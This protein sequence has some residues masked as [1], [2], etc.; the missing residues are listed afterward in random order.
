M[1]NCHIV[2]CVDPEGER[3]QA[4]ADALGIPEAGVFENYPEL[5]STVAPEVVS[6]C[7]PRQA[8]SD[9]VVGIAETGVPAA[10]HCE[11]PLGGT[12][13]ETRNMVAA[14]DRAGVGL[15]FDR[16]RRYSD[17]FR[18]AKALLDDGA[19]G[20]LQRVEGH[21]GPS[22]ESAV[23]AVDACNY[24]DDDRRASWAVAQRATERPDAADAS[25]ADRLFLTWRFEDGVQGR[26]VPEETTGTDADLRLV[27][28]EGFIDLH[29]TEDYAVR[30]RGA[31][32]NTEKRYETLAR[33]ESC[34][35][36]AIATAIDG[37]EGGRRSGPVGDS[38][39]GAPEILFGG[40]E[41]VGRRGRVPLPL[42]GNGHRPRR[43]DVGRRDPQPS[44]D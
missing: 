34:T 32:G 19:I 14:C 29:V 44:D 4:V 8:R 5:L 13:D 12:W 21:W 41:S 10:V 16:G 25:L 43:R 42:D 26:V 1:E 39:L 6:I 31:N 38:P 40:Y 35:Q 30:V 9:L 36:R 20:T 23:A 7:T 27:G 37:L 22:P 15:T 3:G 17:L 2:A 24:F 11:A 18:D 33:G 28:G